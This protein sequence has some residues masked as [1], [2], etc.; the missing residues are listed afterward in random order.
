TAQTIIFEPFVQTEDGRKRVEGTGLGLPISK[1]LVEAHG[2]RLWVESQLGEGTAFY[3]TLP[4]L[5]E[6]SK[7]QI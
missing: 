4:Y 3:F 6:E 1:K 2:G 5:M 7:S